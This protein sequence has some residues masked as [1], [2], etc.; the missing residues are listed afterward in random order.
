VA[1]EAFQ[2]LV[3]YIIISHVKYFK[4]KLK[5]LKQ[6]TQSTSL[7][8]KP[9][10]L[11]LP[12]KA[13]LYKKFPSNIIS[14]EYNISNSEK[15]SNSALKKTS[16]AKLFEENKDNVSSTFIQNKLK[17]PAISSK[18]PQKLI[19][20][21][22]NEIAQISNFKKETSNIENI[23]NQADLMISNLKI[24]PGVRYSD[25]IGN[26]KTNENQYNSPQMNS[27]SNFEKPI[28]MSRTDYLN[29]VK[30]QGNFVRKKYISDETREM[31]PPMPIKNEAVS[32]N[33]NSEKEKG[34][35]P[36][37]NL[38]FDIIDEKSQQMENDNSVHEENQQKDDTQIID[39]VG[40]KVYQHNRS[41]E[42]IKGKKKSDN[43]IINNP[44]YLKELLLCD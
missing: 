3:K 11:F 43:I 35:K 30:N 15:T 26:I 5:K 28:R 20:D 42:E 39:R 7:L 34:K 16:S 13:T 22:S 9:Y 32:K 23:L 12:Q 4:E 6:N 27:M 40:I 37:K 2:E 31:K 36:N 24:N 18:P 29:M 21:K 38:K 17:F 41:K 33:S 19:A 8:Q 25:N 44:I 10:N 1:E 14:M